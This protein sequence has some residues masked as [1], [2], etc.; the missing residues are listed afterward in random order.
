MKYS[1]SIALLVL[2]LQAGMQLFACTVFMCTDGKRTLVGSNEDFKKRNS[3]VWFIPASEGRYGYA[4]FGYDGSVQAG[5]N[6][7]G[8]FWD[9]LRAYPYTEAGNICERLDIGGNVLHK[10][11]EECATVDDV[12]SLFEKYYWEG[13]RVAQ[14]MVV[15]K[16]GENAII[17]YY[18]NELTVTK[19]AGNHQVCTNFR[20]N[21][22]EDSENFHWYNIG[23]RRLRKA[24]KMINE[25]EM[26]V[27]NFFS[28]LD[29]THQNNIVAKTIYSTVCDLGTGDIYISVNGDFDQIFKINISEELHK[30]KHSYFL[31][32]LV[33]NEINNIR[34]IE[35]HDDRYLTGNNEVILLDKKWE[36]TTRR[37]KAKYYRKIEKDPESNLYIMKD[38]FMNDT[39]QGVSYYSS[40]NPEILDGRYL[41]YYESGNI[42]VEGYFKH[43][44]MDGEWSYW[45]ADGKLDSIVKY[46]DGIK[47]SVKYVPS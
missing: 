15:D 32:D 7:K 12:I 13:F 10:I 37:K 11:A 38:Y 3:Q 1:K 14:L 31:S 44:L 24:E 4:L 45:S 2:L 46:K 30:G 42:K 40:L 34:D 23:S 21:C 25:L 29:A 36:K 35:I 5:I 16:T 6:E 17:T 41:V 47:Q 22:R 8:L 19:K 18:N 27:D 9:G 20:I 26:T 43:R 33:I 39:L 28:I